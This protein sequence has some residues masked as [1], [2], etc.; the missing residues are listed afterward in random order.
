M[1]EMNKLTSGEKPVLIEFYSEQCGPCRLMN[2]ILDEVEEEM[3]EKV[4]FKRI[5]T[6]KNKSISIDFNVTYGLKGTPT[7]FIFSDNKLVLRHQGV[8]FAEDLKE[9]LR[10]LIN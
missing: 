1:E 4:K 5:D 10:S 9:R 2:T 6:D 8:M 3:G 7:L